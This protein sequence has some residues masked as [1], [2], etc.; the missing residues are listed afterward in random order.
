MTTHKCL[1]NCPECLA[2][3]TTIRDGFAKLVTHLG[4][5]DVR[6]VSPELQKPKKKRIVPMSLARIEEVDEEYQPEGKLFSPTSPIYSPTET[7]DA[8]P[9]A[10][11]CSCPGP[12][13]D[14]SCAHCAK[15][16][17]Q[18]QEKEWQKSEDLLALERLR[19]LDLSGSAS[20]AESKRRAPPA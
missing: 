5:R 3:M 16:F 7:K 11:S 13:P 4:V 12:S 19:E 14:G 10:T 9:E 20:V 2:L 17:R 6:A 18:L 1:T 8:A 15:M